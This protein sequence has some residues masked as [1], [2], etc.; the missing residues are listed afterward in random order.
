[1]RALAIVVLG[2]VGCHTPSTSKVIRT[3]E[4]PKSQASSPPVEAKVSE[5]LPPVVE[6][7]DT[8]F[9]EELIDSYFSS[10]QSEVAM[11]LYRRQ[12][13]PQAIAVIVQALAQEPGAQKRPLKILLAAAKRES[14]AYAEAGHLFA[15]AVA[16]NKIIADYLHFEAAQ[17]FAAAGDP[18]AILH[19][20]KV[21]PAGPW[22]AKSS[23]YLQEQREP[24]NSIPRL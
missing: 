8:S 23:F 22:G 6:E 5:D 9:P 3:G 10:G 17:A 16:D 14:G 1:M 2:L 24:K 13:Y 19:A 11:R 7:R 21:D 4:E 18:K 12:L 15:Q 20:E